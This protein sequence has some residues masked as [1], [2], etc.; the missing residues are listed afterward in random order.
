[1]RVVIKGNK[2]EAALEA[3]RRG[4]PFTFYFEHAD[5]VREYVIT[6]VDVPDGFWNDVVEWFCEPPMLPPFPVGACLHYGPR[7]RI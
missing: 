1:M 6:S 3:A 4:M 5:Q 2:H 7:C